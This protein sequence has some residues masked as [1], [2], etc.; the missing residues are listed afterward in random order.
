MQN[1]SDPFARQR[2]ST[3]KIS[4]RGCAMRQAC[5]HN[6]KELTAPLRRIDE[7]IPDSEQ[8]GELPTLGCFAG[9]S[10]I[11]VAVASI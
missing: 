7:Q 11:R 6:V 8:C 4:E 9:A 2:K 10:R 1:D 5:C 3:A